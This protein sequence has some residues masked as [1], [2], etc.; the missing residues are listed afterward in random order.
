MI[1]YQSNEPQTANGHWK[2]VGRLRIVHLQVS[3]VCGKTD[4]T[5]NAHSDGF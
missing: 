2:H 1:F 4:M 3:L 5:D